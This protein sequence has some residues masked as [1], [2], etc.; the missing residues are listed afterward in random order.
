M[1]GTEVQ[2]RSKV[3]RK[4]NVVGGGRKE[5]NAKKNEKKT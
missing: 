2:K 5:K 1:G 4:E 3:G